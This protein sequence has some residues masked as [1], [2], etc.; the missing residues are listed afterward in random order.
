[1]KT[2]L[3]K[4]VLCLYALAG[5][6]FSCKN[7]DVPEADPEKPEIEIEFTSG[8]SGEYQVKTGTNITLSVTVTHAINP[9]YSWKIDGKIV[10]VEPQFIFVAGKLGEYFVN[11]RVDAE[12]GSAEKQVKISVFNKLPPQ[13]TLESATIA[14]SGIDRV[15]VAE[16]S[17]AEDAVYVWR[18]NGKLVSE[19]ATYTFNQTVLGDYS[20]SLKVTTDEGQDM[21]TVAIT[22]MPEPLP[23]LYFDN[24]RYRVASNTAERRTMTVPSGKSLVLAPVIRNIDHPTTFVWTV[25]G[26]TQTATG[27][28]FTFSPAAQGTCLVTVTEQSTGATGEVE[29]T[30]TPPEGAFR[31]TN[32][33]KKHA[34]NAFDYIPAPGRYIGSMTGM[35]IVSALKD[36]QE[37]CDAGAD[38]MYMIGAFGGYYIVGFDHSVR[39]EPDKAD[40]QINGNP[41]GQNWCESGIVW[42]MQDE[43]GN[44]LPDDTWYELKGSE[45]G[46]PATKQRY[47]C[48]YYKP[49]DASSSVVTWTDNTG[50]SGAVT[51]GPYPRIITEDYYTLTG[52]CLA[53]TVLEAGLSYSS[54]YDWGYVDGINSSPIRPV[55]G[56]FWIEDAIQ[57][58][59]SPASLQYVDFVKVHTAINAMTQNV[60]EIST[61]PKMPYDLNFV[62]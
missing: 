26:V 2:N 27:E 44:G 45:T 29:V 47:A 6:L 7:E 25:D 54:C 36:L 15:F 5:M 18:L 52:T 24:G 33:V 58:D 12:N 32:G 21:K 61:E 14:F 22:V 55:T 40:L 49:K 39:N 56:H 9:V 23:E 20:L 38:G 48:T 16:V 28:Y 53:S 31:R 13:I 4:S 46:K 57:V 51:T 62:E 8:S 11:F 1:M 59:G 37:W 42:V 41:L 50:K 30:C 35:T 43:N 17:D 3:L 34:T 60:G 19:T 10:G